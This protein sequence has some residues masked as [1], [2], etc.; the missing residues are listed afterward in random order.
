[1][2][3]QQTTDTAL[4]QNIKLLP[5]DKREKIGE[6]LFTAS[7]A[8]NSVEFHLQK[9]PLEGHSLFDGQKHPTLWTQI[10]ALKKM[11]VG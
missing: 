3:A 4:L 10:Y 9:T 7:M 1:M 11:F 5:K 6:L 8:L 2:K